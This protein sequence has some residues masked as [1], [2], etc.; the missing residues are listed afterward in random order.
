MQRRCGPE[1]SVELAPQLGWGVAV[2]T[3]VGVGDTGV[4]VAS[5][6]DVKSGLPSGTV[7]KLSAFLT[8]MRALS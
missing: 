3:R 4:G 6:L 5:G 2:G 7:H 8:R 1:H